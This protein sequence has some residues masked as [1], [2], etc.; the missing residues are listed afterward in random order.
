MEINEYYQCECVCGVC[1]PHFCVC[2]DGWVGGWVCMSV[3]VGVGF[4]DVDVC[5]CVGDHVLMWYSSIF[6]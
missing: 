2:V 1:A 3:G 4:V 5:G 6:Y